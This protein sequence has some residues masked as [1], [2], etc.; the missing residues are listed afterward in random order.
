MP[1]LEKLEITIQN[2]VEAEQIISTVKNIKRLNGV[3]INRD[4][5]ELAHDLDFHEFPTSKMMD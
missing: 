2:E 5:L 1:L 3:E 4:V